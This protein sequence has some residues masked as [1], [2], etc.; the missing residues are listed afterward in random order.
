VAFRPRVG[1]WTQAT[2]KFAP[3]RDATA[4]AII[5]ALPEKSAFHI[6]DLLLYTR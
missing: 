3:R 1:K 4:D 6:D 2:L 5:F